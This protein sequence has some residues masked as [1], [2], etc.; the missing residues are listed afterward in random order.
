MPAGAAAD[1]LVAGAL[2]AVRTYC[3]WH[4]L[5]ERSETLTLDGSGHQRMQLPSTFVTAVTRVAEDGEDLP[6]TAYRW[7]RDGLIRKRVG[8]WLDE[9]AAVEVELTHGYAEADDVV[10]V[11]LAVAA[12]EATNPLALSSQTVGGMSFSHGVTGGGFMADEYA[13]LDPYRAVVDG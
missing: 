2:S 7:Q 3:G 5:G 11:V 13:A 6:A 9:Y 1:R 12:R 8:V 10:R 4:V